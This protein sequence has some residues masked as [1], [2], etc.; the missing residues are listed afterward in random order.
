MAQYEAVTGRRPSYLYSDLIRAEAPAAKNRYFNNLAMTQQENQFNQELSLQEDIAEEQQDQANMSNLISGA[1]LAVEAA[2][3]AT[4]AGKSALDAGGAAVDYGS[5]L[6]STSAPAADATTSAASSATP[7]VK[8]AAVASDVLLAEG[9]GAATAPS[10]LSGAGADVA[11][12]ELAIAESGGAGGTTSGVGG[13]AGAAPL[14]WILAAIAAQ[15]MAGQSTD[16][17]FEGQP[18]GTF[19]SM[20]DEGNWRPRVANDPWK[21]W[22]NDELGLNPSSGE[23]MD[24][25]IQ[26]GDWENIAKRTPATAN[27]W[28]DPVGDLGYD[29]IQEGV[30]GLTGLG[31]QESDAVMSLINPVAATGKILEDTW[32]CSQVKKHVGFKMSDLRA[33]AQLRK[34]GMKNHTELTEHYIEYGPELIYGISEKES[35][36]TFYASLSDTFVSPVIELVKSGD[37]EKAY[38]LYRDTTL[39]LTA[40]YAP[41]VYPEHANA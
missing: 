27:Q 7:A 37:M 39:K 41:Q 31:D 21:G 15:E 3:Y 14:G 17:V 38:Q 8:P 26:N 20:N 1:G 2:P 32:I 5:S 35:Q 22:V 10:T 29:V 23:K 28:V 16:T 24:A 19:F 6:F 4:K 40:Q 13:A 18:T 33:L 34:F 30:E 11:A 25:A 12:T 36:K 9:A